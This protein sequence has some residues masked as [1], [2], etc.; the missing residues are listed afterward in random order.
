MKLEFIINK[1]L[2]IWNLLYQSSVSEDI[3]KLKQKLWNNHKREYTEIYKE[4][5]N[6]IKYLN[7]YI[8]D[9]DM[10]FNLVEANMNFKRFKQETNRYRLTLLEIWD[11]NK[12]IYNRELNK[13]L[14]FDLDDVYKVCVLHPS[15]DAV[16]AYFNFDTNV[17]TLGKKITMKEK[18]SFL[19][20]LTYKIIKNELDKI[21]TDEKDIITVI[22]ELITVNELY[23]RVTNESKYSIGK[24]ELKDLKQKIYPYWLMYL[25]I[26]VE[27]MEKYMIRDNIFFKTNDYVYEDKLKYVDIYSFINFI[28]NHKRKILKTR[29]ITVEEIE[30]L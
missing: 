1:H 13:I 27:D 19:T 23:T 24:K 15:I 16:D 17:I 2:L 29:S 4:K 8:P 30:I 21:K 18:D 10:I 26:S 12:K 11:S 9:D 25:G 22:S 6:I 3:H 5:D 20:Y 7:D 14:K 28:L